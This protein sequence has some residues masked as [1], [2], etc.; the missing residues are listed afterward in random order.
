M[1][2]D[3]GVLG[4]SSSSR[5]RSSLFLAGGH[6]EVNEV[7]D[8]GDDLLNSVPKWIPDSKVSLD[9]KPLDCDRRG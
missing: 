2:D 4:S 7:I 6:V 5:S 3:G 8:D 1:D 9:S